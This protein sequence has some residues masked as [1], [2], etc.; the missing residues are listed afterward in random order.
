MI[1]LLFV[2]DGIKIENKNNL[3]EWASMRAL[4]GTQKKDMIGIV[5]VHCARMLAAA[6][7]AG[8]G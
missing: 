1:I 7:A 6:A 2:C 4:T 5:S 8:S 3:Q